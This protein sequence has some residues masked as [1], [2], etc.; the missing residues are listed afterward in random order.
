MATL[1]RFQCKVGWKVTLGN[2]RDI[3]VFKM[4]E[5]YQKNGMSADGLT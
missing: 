4:H 3:E 1:K 5:K 2:S